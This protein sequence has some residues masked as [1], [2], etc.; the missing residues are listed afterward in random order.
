MIDDLRC[1][2]KKPSSWDLLI[3][4]LPFGQKTQLTTLQQVQLEPQ[5]VHSNIQLKRDVF[6]VVNRLFVEPNT[7]SSH[8]VE[9]QT[10]LLRSA[11][12]EPRPH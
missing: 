7:Q 9:P 2:V 5:L 3:V 10:A 8:A 4:S 1:V 11:D 12:L 6:V